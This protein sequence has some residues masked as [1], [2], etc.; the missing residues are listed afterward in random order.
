VNPEAIKQLVSMRHSPLRNYIVPGLTSWLI[1]D[2]GEAGKLRMFDSSREQHEFITPHSHR[3]DFLACVAQG[4]VE[5][6]TWFESDCED[7]E[8]YQMT[9][10]TYLDEPGKF[11]SEIWTRENF[12]TDVIEYK[13]GDCYSMKFNEIHSIKFSKG[14]K[15]LFFEGPAKV[16]CSYVLE[17]LIDGVHSAFSTPPSITQA[18]KSKRWL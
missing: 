14:A 4:S 13:E 11:K 2:N 17:P 16:D 3:F 6:M 7:S 18:V 12:I 15:V 9:R 5:N 1:M 10:T 8:T